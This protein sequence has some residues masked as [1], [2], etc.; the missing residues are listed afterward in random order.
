MQYTALVDNVRNLGIVQIS[1]NEVLYTLLIC[2]HKEIMVQIYSMKCYLFL[3]NGSYN[4]YIVTPN[5]MYRTR[6]EEAVKNLNVLLLCEGDPNM[7]PQ[8]CHFG[9]I[10]CFEL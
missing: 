2:H 9:I 5:S 4:D 7:P 10:I 6:W 1:H 8:L 3:K